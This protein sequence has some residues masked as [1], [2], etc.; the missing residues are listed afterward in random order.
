MHG[1]KCDVS[2]DALCDDRFFILGGVLEL[3]KLSGAQGKDH[4]LVVFLEL[5]VDLGEHQSGEVAVAEAFIFEKGFSRW[6]CQCDALKNGSTK[7]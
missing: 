1:A 5:V 7:L 6:E 3:E 4:G 2:V